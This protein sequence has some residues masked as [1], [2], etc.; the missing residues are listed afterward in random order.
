MIC[1]FSW[2]FTA[3]TFSVSLAGFCFSASSSAV[4]VSQNSALGHPL[5]F[6]YIYSLGDL[7]PSHASNPTCIPIAQISSI[8][9]HLFKLQLDIYNSILAI[10][11][12]VSQ[13][14]HFQNW[15]PHF[16]PLNL[17]LWWTPQS[18][19]MATSSFPLLGTK[20]LFW[21]HPTPNLMANWFVLPPKYILDPAISH[22]LPCDQPAATLSLLSPRLLLGGSSFVFAPYSLVLTQSPVW[23]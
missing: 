2:C 17:L 1:W 4:E 8:L 6:I 23:S 22:H 16:S 18:Q 12:W 13:T 19:F 15:S 21:L 3:S 9:Y 20:S 7:I 10:S 11:P 14:Y 5:C